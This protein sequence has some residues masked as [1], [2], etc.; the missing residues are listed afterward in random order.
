M[1]VLHNLAG[2]AVSDRSAIAELSKAIKDALDAAAS[3]DYSLDALLQRKDPEA[4]A[5]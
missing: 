2:E 3:A 1:P 5:R 4:A